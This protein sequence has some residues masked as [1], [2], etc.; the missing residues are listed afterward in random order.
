MSGKGCGSGDVVGRSCSGVRASFLLSMG[1]GEGCS[2][3]GMTLGSGL[4]TSF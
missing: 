4:I 1:S 3:T 2:K